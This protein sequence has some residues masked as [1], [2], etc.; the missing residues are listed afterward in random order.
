MREIAGRLVPGRHL[1]ERSR[2]AEARRADPGLV[3]EG[4][5]GLEPAAEKLSR[6]RCGGLT[7]A[8]SRFTRRLTVLQE[9]AAARTGFGNA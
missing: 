3:R 4:L 6:I 7:F 8:A 5:L 2:R 9:S 1:R